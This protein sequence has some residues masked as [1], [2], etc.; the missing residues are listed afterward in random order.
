MVQNRAALAVRAGTHGRRGG[1]AICGE[2][3]GRARRIVHRHDRLRVERRHSRAETLSNLHE[4]R[5]NLARR[6]RR[7][8]QNEVG[9]KAD[10]AE[11]EIEQRLN[12][13]RRPACERHR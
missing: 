6:R 13:V 2:N 7:E 12:G 9:A 3:H 10:R 1:V 8:I 11:V 4:A 5:R